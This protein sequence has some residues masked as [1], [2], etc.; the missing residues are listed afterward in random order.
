[1][2]SDSTVTLFDGKKRKSV[3]TH[4]RLP[5]TVRLDRRLDVSL[6]ELE[7]VLPV[8]K[9]ARQQSGIRDDVPR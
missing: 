9:H 7:R 4:K 6:G 5:A 2:V 8:G 3:G 1:M